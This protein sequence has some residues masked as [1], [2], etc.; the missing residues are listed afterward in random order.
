MTRTRRDW[1]PD[2]RP[3]ADAPPTVRAPSEG[4]AVSEHLK[5]FAP[6]DSQSEVLNRARPRA[7]SK[8]SVSR[9]HVDRGARSSGQVEQRFP[10]YDVVAGRAAA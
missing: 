6:S 8:R 4:A 3:G 9:L 10:A 5:E 7:H 1:P 2:R